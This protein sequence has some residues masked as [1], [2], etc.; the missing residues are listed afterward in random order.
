MPSPSDATA[1]APDLTSTELYAQLEDVKAGRDE[2]IEAEEISAEDVAAAAGLLRHLEASL[3]ALTWA[4]ADVVRSDQ[5]LKE[6][7]DDDIDETRRQNDALHVARSRLSGI[8]Q[9]QLLVLTDT[10]GLGEDEDDSEDGAGE[11]AR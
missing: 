3:T 10:L 1:P 6:A 7:G 8:V 9:E 5:E 4:E 2:L 11:P